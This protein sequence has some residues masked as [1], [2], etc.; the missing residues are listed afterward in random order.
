MLTG[1]NAQQN[2]T[3]L[4][5]KIHAR[6]SSTYLLDGHAVNITA[7]IGVAISKGEG[8]S[9]NDLIKRADSAMYHAKVAGQTAKHLETYKAP[10]SKSKG[11]IFLCPYNL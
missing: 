8:E 11:H 4:T 3:A 1:I 7:S 10:I 5:D 9:S 2:A 6:L